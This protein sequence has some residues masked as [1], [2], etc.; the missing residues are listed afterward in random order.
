[1]FN[2]KFIPHNNNN[3]QIHLNIFFF[4]LEVIAGFCETTFQRIY[5]LPEPKLPVKYPRM[6]G[7][8]PAAEEN[9]FNAW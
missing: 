7:N 6:I 3:V 2:S 1:M 4:T 9:P 5:D 8:Q